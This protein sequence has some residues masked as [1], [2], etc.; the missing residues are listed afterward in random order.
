MVTPTSIVD[1]ASNLLIVFST[2][3]V[4]SPFVLFLYNAALV[5]IICDLVRIVDVSPSKAE[6][7]RKPRPCR[8]EAFHFFP[9]S[10]ACTKCRHLRDSAQPTFP[11]NLKNLLKGVLVH[12]VKALLVVAKTFIAARPKPGPQIWRWYYSAVA[13]RG[14]I[15]PGKDRLPMVVVPSSFL[16]IAK[17]LVSSVYLLEPYLSLFQGILVLIRVP[18]ER[19]L[20][21]CLLQPIGVNVSL[22]AKHLV[23]APHLGHHCASRCTRFT[24]SL[25]APRSAGNVRTDAQLIPLCP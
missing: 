13:S 10:C 12:R 14:S 11:F 4:P 22:Y 5:P 1:Q 7:G 17:H 8:V 16:R 15:S 2:G 9:R 21:V 23:V 3:S 6:R 18:P 24:A 20:P 25:Q 19:H